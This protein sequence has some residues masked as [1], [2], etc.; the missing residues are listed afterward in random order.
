MSA[1]AGS[2]VWLRGTPALRVAE[3]W[4]SDQVAASACGGHRKRRSRTESV[5]AAGEKMTA[6]RRDYDASELKNK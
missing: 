2:R 6:T 3:L 1:R 5:P 4:S